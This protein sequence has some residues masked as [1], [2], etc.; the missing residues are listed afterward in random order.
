M[1]RTITYEVYVQ[2]GA[3]WQ[4]H[5]RHPGTAKDAAVAEAK[6]LE[7]LPSVKAV[8]VI[9]ETYNANE[10]LADESIIYKSADD[11]GEGLGRG[12]IDE[13]DE[14]ED[15]RRPSR[16]VVLKGGGGRGKRTSITSSIYD[17][18]DEGEE[19]ESRGL[20]ITVKILLIA[21]FGI[22]AGGLIAGLAALGMNE[23]PKFG[24]PVTASLY[25]NV[26]FTV[27]I[28]GFLLAAVPTALKVFRGE[29]LAS[30]A[31][32]TEKRQAK[33]PAQAPA[34]KVQA[35]DVQTTAEQPAAGDQPATAEQA[36]EQA[37]EAIN[38]EET[39]ARSQAEPQKMVMMGFLTKGLSEVKRV[40][41]KLAQTDLFGINLF[42]AGACE[43]L[44]QARNLQPRSIQVLVSDVV[45]VM[46]TRKDQAASF[47]ERSAEYLMTDSRYMQMYEAGR[48]SM[49]GQLGGEER[50]GA[51]MAKAIEVW[52]QPKA[53][54][55][56]RSNG[57]ISVMFT[58]MVGSTALTQTRGDALAQQVVRAHNRIVRDALNRFAG[59]E[60]KHTGDGIMASFA[61]TSNAVEA[62]IAIQAA[63]QEH[64]RNNPDLPLQLKIGINAGEPIA[65]DDDLFG[66]TVQLAARIVDKA[67]AGQIFVSEIVRGICAG[68]PLPFKNIGGFDL[69]GF[70]EPVVVFEVNWQD[71]MAATKTAGASGTNTAGAQPAAASAK[72]P[73]RAPA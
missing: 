62:A 15:D 17:F 11:S 5:A 33:R 48:N 21:L 1:A 12:R 39:L 43:A 61:T 42:L 51:D 30:R 36:L 31:A 70:A 68:K 16:G 19:K 28:M 20:A 58:D 64:S 26:V 41:P 40:R 54:N 23:L 38:P 50:A 35:A 57:P 14:E 52:N 6:S 13:E 60:I 2:Q 3:R 73:A 37:L 47:A 9:R 56:P 8:R 29:R 7:K 46:G 66:T 34:Q 59:R 71:L 55:E 63:V 18:E 44:G 45:Q 65:E 67:K 10:G 72:R 32:R 4:I 27:F 53:S 25:G 24:L 49:N 22:A 69:K